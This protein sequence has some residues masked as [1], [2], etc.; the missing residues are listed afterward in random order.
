MG[1][2]QP[3]DV[4]TDGPTNGLT[5][6]HSEAPKNAPKN[7]FGNG[8]PFQ[9]VTKRWNDWI[10]TGPWLAHISWQRQSIN[11][12]KATQL[13]LSVSLGSRKKIIEI[14]KVIVNPVRD[15]DKKEKLSVL[16]LY[17]DIHLNCWKQN[18]RYFH[19]LREFSK[20]KKLQF[21]CIIFNQLS[22]PNR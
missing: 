16:T 12:I 22:F 17:S 7:K 5:N 15:S 18:I 6:Q 3:S 20:V 21:C 11:R 9:R 13:C 2:D 8:Y 19:I 1:T 4:R 14:H 10:R